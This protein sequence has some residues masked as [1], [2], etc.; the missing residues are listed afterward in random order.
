MTT[1][2]E[3]DYLNDWVLENNPNEF[4]A[5]RYLSPDAQYIWHLTVWRENGS[6]ELSQSP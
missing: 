6:P 4:E 1:K 3:W 2:P 5:G